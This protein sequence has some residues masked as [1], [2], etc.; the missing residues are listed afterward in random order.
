LDKLSKTILG[1]NVEKI[2]ENENGEFG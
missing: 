1:H 2:S